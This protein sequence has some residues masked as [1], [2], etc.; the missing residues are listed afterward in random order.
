[1]TI[2]RANATAQ[3]PARYRDVAGA[4]GASTLSLG[5]R[6]DTCTLTRASP[7]VHAA[8]DHEV[9]GGHVRALL[10]GQEQRYVGHVLRPAETPEE[11]PIEHLAGK[12][13]VAFG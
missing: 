12:S 2:E 7:D 1:M 5:T 13:A 9:D 10:G 6:S 4:G 11:R 8:I 3:K